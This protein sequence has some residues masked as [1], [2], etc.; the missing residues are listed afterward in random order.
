MLFHNHVAW[1]FMPV[2]PKVIIQMIP[3]TEWTD[4][5]G[6]QLS[7]YLSFCPRPFIRSAVSSLRYTQSLLLHFV[8]AQ[9]WEQRRGKLSNKSWCC[10]TRR[11]FRHFRHLFHN[12]TIAKIRQLPKSPVQ[13]RSDFVD[14]LLMEHDSAR[15]QLW[16]YF[17]EA[18]EITES[19][20]ADYLSN[21]ED[22]ENR[23]AR[24][25]IQW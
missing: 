23:L 8:R 13:E 14:F 2:F 20:F 7:I 24:G 5:D 22:Y 16:A 6:R 19:D 11:H 10:Q 17:A 3:R 18:S 12:V 21:L 25:E 1:G 4:A 15:W 9:A